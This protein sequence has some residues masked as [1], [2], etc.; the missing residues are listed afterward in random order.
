MLFRSTASREEAVAEGAVFNGSAPYELISSKTWSTED[1]EK[2]EQITRTLFVI[3]YAVPEVFDSV[4]RLA[5]H[6]RLTGIDALTKF[7]S[8]QSPE[9]A[10]PKV[11]PAEEVYLFQL[12]CSVRDDPRYAETRAALRRRCL[13]V[14]ASASSA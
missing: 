7:L 3:Q 5:T 4:K 13:V 2:A 10:W 12:C 6:R 14:L 9:E 11:Q 1:L 8:R